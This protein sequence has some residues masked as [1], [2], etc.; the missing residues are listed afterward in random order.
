MKWSLKKKLTLSNASVA[1]I[2]CLLVALVWAMRQDLSDQFW[3]FEEKVLASGQ[4]YSYELATNISNDL[5]Q[6]D[7]RRSKVI[8]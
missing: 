1:L 8:S 7:R 2:S 4:Y 5:K 3:G 6:A